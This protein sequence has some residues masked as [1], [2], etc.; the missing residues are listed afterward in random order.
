MVRAE[1]KQFLGRARARREPLV[2]LDIPLLFETGG[3]RRCDYVLV[4]SA[5][6][7]IQRQRVLQRPGMTEFAWRRSC[8]SRCR[9]ARS[10]GEP[11]S[12]CRPGWGGP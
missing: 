10:G 5:P 11:I 9:I 8:R 2:V 7:L 4:V 6:A 1:E 12:S 3:E